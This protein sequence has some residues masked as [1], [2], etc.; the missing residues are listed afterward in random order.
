VRNFLILK[1]S[2]FISITFILHFN[3]FQNISDFKIFFE[4]QMQNSS[5]RKCQTET[6]SHKPKLKKWF[7]VNKSFKTHPSYQKLQFR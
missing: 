6:F 5:H 3:E 1:H 4:Q 2:I 7:P